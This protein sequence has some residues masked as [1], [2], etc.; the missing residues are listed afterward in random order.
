[1][2]RP[3][4]ILLTTTLLVGAWVTLIAL[5][6]D[7]V[8]AVFTSRAIAK[9]TISVGRLHID[10]EKADGLPAPNPRAVE[11]TSPWATDV[12]ISHTLDVRNDGTL[13][14]GKMWLA[15]QLQPTLQPEL[16]S[17]LTLTVAVSGAAGTQTET[18]SVPSWQTARTDSALAGI[19]PGQTVHV[20][21]KLSGTLPQALHGTGLLDIRL[22][23]TA[24]E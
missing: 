2:S 13:R 23:I 21:V 16:L 8:L 3:T 6:A 22:L 10:I 4:R 7:G 5:S 17:Q 15:V 18:G 11:W 9:Q 14:V 24:T 12:E 19:K 20:D 1:M